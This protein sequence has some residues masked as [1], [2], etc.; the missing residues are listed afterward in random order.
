MKRGLLLIFGIIFVIALSLLSAGCVAQTLCNETAYVED[1]YEVQYEIDVT[2]P[3]VTLTVDLD[4][5]GAPV[6][7]AVLDETNFRIFEEGFSSSGTF[8]N[9]R[10]VLSCP[11]VIRT[12]KTCTLSKKGVYYVVIENSDFLPNGADAGRGVKYSITITAE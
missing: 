2:D 5:D 4:T 1:D 8:E 6:D 7:L 3:P 10:T 11:S 9:F 12:T